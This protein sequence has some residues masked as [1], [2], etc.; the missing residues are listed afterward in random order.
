MSSKGS[1]SQEERENRAIL[2]YDGIIRFDYV[3]RC[4]KCAVKVENPRRQVLG[5][6]VSC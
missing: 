3:G 4:G 2:G 6:L 1:Q 5:F